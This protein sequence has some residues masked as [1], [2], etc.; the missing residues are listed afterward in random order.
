MNP[1][2]SLA[3]SA[4]GIACGLT[5]GIVCGLAML[6]GAPVASA[7]EYPAPQP[8]SVVLRDFRFQTGEVLPELRLT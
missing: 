6:C 2:R 4:R 1:I 5:R 3:G 8:G 7:A